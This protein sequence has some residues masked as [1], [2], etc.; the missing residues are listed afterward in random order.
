MTEPMTL[1]V[2]TRAAAKEVHRALTDADALRTWLAEDA[3]VEPP[4]RF[5]FW[6]RYTPEGD[7][8]HQ[9]LL[10]LDEQTLRF[11]WLL[12]GERTTTEIT[13]AE[14]PDGG[15]VVTL[16]QSHFDFQDV[17]TGAI[18][19]VLQTF[20]ALALANLVDYLEG[21]E[22]TPKVDYTGTGMRA[23]FAID[24]EIG[25]VWASLLDSEQVTTWFGF[26][27][28]I[29]PR[30]G[31]RFAMGGL[32]NNPDPAMILELVP[33]RRVSIDWGDAGVATWELEGSGGSTRLTLMQSGF[34]ENR[35]PYAAWGGILAGVASLRR[36]HELPDQPIV[37]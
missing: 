20:W 4:D 28:E 14:Q 6:G 13:L 26:P 37:A 31:G 5:A 29:E 22:L 18:R 12:D 17:F 7:A 19:G 15:T 2:R 30:V 11:A 8:P 34:D 3:D 1:R 16:T 24:R 21:R 23:E 35:P 32:D 36:Y 25:P 27:I 9:E 33:E 10:H